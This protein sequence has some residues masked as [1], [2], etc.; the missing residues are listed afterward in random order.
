MA[1][2]TTTNL[3]LTKPEVGASTDT[4]GTKLNTDLDTIDACFSATGTSVAMN[5]DAA[6]ID[7]SVIGG[8]TAAAGSF[9]T[10]TASGDLTVDTSTLKVDSTNN[11]VGVGTASPSYNF[12]AYTTG[13]PVARF[14]RNGGSAATQGWTQ[15]GHSA[16]GYSGSTGADSYFVAEHGFGF[17]VNEGTNTMTI[18]DGGNVGIG[19]SSPA[20]TLDVAGNANLTADDARLL[21]EEADGT[22]I[23]WIG[24]ITGAGVGGCFLYNHGGTATVQLRADATAGFINN[25]ANFGIGTASP[26]TD[27]QIGDYSDA[28]ETITI[29]TSGNGT[30]RINFYDNNASEGG[31]IRVVGESGGSKMYFTNRW[32]SDSDRV[33]FD[34]VN[35]RVGIGNTIGSF[36]SSVLPLVVGS[37]SGDEGM[38]ILSGS[39][40]KGKIG[41][42]DAATDDSG[43]YRGYLQYDH[44]GDNLNI[45]TAGSEVIRID[46]AGRLLVGTTATGYP[47]GKLH[48]WTSTASQYAASFRHD[49]AATTS[50]GI[51]VICGTDD[52]SGTSTLINFQDGDG[53]GV[54][55]VTFSGST[56]AYN[57]SSDE[58]LKD[59]TGDAKGLEIINQLKPVDFT[60]KKGGQK[61]IG[62]IAQ[63]AMEHV[64]SAVVENPETGYY[65]MD[66]S[67]LVT[68]LI[69]AV[70]EQQ[71]QIEELKGEIDQLKQQAHD[72]CDN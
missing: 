7:N 57:T 49:G 69:K 13:Y 22:D 23:T 5:L 66:Y 62:L 48:A 8:T 17:A 63:E 34:L 51:A 39:S 3:S 1:D 4:W 14:E 21:I 20:V 28:A 33:T 25:G 72:K 16:L 9:T 60:W 44:S 64:P 54:G 42:A 46:S 52:G 47:D 55:S 11:R 56:T 41:F 19:T 10:L 50:Y 18:T 32:T 29:A 38:A 58:R 40:S 61:G 15:I 71:E 65:Q 35:G 30:G 67:K 59:I 53:S 24:D 6:V 31:S 43:S 26:A 37:G 27:L 2:T 70:Q 68:P 45:G 36:H 12:H